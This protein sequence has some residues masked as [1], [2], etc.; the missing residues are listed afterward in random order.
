MVSILEPLGTYSH[1]LWS[2]VEM[3]DQS[4]I[5]GVVS[6]KFTFGGGAGRAVEKSVLG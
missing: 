3:T 5:E 2:L 4:M 6:R 1:G